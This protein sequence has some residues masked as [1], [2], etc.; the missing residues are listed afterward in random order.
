MTND[1]TKEENGKRLDAVFNRNA[2]QIISILN[3][4]PEACGYG[5]GIDPETDTTYFTI[6]LPK[7]SKKDISDIP[8]TI[9]PD[10]IP[11]KIIYLPPAKK[12]L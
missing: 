11:V 12:S 7:G 1:K 6:G 10:K 4:H 3:A 9:G 5:A 2:V 8:A